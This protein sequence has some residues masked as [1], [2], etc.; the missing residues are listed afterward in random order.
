MWI[1]KWILTVFFMLIVLLFA[2]QNQE[3][4]VSIRFLNWISP[5]LP[6]YLLLYIAFASGILMWVLL[7]IMNILRL[8]NQIH[9]LQR[10]NKKV[11]E[12]L[13]HLRNASIEEEL[14]PTETD[15]EEEIEKKA[16]SRK[17]R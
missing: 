16:L 9:R 17:K 15:E 7:S 13:N 12:E 8:N 4:T 3:Q 1:F 5:N 10:E 14:T 2:I 11:K 6:L